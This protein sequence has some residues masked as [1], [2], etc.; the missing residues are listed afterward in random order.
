MTEK[1]M[2][3]WGISSVGFG[4]LSVLIPVFIVTLG[5]GPGMLGLAA[6]MSAAASVPAALVFGKYI[7]S[8]RNFHSFLPACTLASA[9]F[10]A[11]NILAKS[12]IL[13]VFLNTATVF[14]FSAM[15]PALSLLTVSRAE[16]SEWSG[17]L[18]TLNSFQGWGWAAGLLSGA[19]WMAVLPM[20]YDQ[21]FAQRTLLIACSALIGTGALFKYRTVPGRPPSVKSDKRLKK[22]ASRAARSGTTGVRASIG[23]IYPAAI[24][25]GLKNIDIS[26][27]SKKFPRSLWISL[28][29]SLAFFMAFSIF[30]APLPAYLGSTGF[31]QTSIFA[32]YLVAALGSAVFYSRAGGVVSRYGDHIHFISLAARAVLMPAVFYAAVTGSALV[33]TGG[34]LFLMGLSWALIAVSVGS[35]TARLAP[36]DLK[37]EAMG[38]YSAVSSL[39]AAI[40]ALMG[41]Y[42]AEFSY[43]TAFSIAGGIA[44]ISAAAV[45]ASRK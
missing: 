26:R 30:F 32:L 6:A 35:R 41:G 29:V 17:L 27:I 15:T 16:E 23:F 31:D 25:L 5:G 10:V 34:L 38:L 21:L 20:Y 2:Y 37:G 9:V 3:G 33:W 12:P 19:V 42:I 11:L 45:Y 28:S 40:G 7:D 43:L 24:Y 4:A 36:S 1:W 22:L 8:K 13:V 44:L 18:G 39:G 14:W